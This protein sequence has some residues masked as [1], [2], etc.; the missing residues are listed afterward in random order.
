MSVI[1]ESPEVLYLHLEKI[2]KKN[3]KYK[4]ALEDIVTRGKGPGGAVVTT[5]ETLRS[6]AKAALESK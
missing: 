1:K 3:E 4:Q 2:I 6:I 5:T